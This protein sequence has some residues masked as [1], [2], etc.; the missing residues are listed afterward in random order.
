VKRLLI[1]AVSLSHKSGWFGQ[2]CRR[3]RHSNAKY[4]HQGRRVL[5]RFNGGGERHGQWRWRDDCLWR[6]QHRRRPHGNRSCA[7]WYDAQVAYE[8]AGRTDAD[9]AI[10]ANF[11]PITTGS[12]AKWGWCKGRAAP[13]MPRQK[14]VIAAKT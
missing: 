10:G 12:P 8:S 7:S 4:F 13:A 3:S 1:V 14:E 2:Q 11:D 5:R 6:Y 9:P